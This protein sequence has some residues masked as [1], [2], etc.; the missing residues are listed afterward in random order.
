MF[1][2][3]LHP[4]YTILVQNSARQDNTWYICEADNIIRHYKGNRAFADLR[5]GE[6]DSISTSTLSFAATKE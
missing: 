6:E 4:F 1:G 2:W 5:Y 3:T